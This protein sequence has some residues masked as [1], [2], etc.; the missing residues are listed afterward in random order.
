MMTPN[1]KTREYGTYETVKA[2]YETVK[3]TYETVKA[4]DSQG[5]MPVAEGLI[6]PH[7]D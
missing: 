7:A 3:A 1:P 5:H 2:T 6:D 4:T